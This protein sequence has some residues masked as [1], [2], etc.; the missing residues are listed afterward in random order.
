MNLDK[1]DKLQKLVQVR[2]TIQLAKVNEARRK[3]NQTREEI[4]FSYKKAEIIK[5]DGAGA[6]DSFLA[7]NDMKE[8]SYISRLTQLR[9]LKSKIDH[10]ITEIY[11]EI[12]RKKIAAIEI[13]KQIIV[14]QMEYEQARKRAE[15]IDTL[16]GIIKKEDHISR[17]NAQEADIIDSS[18][19]VNPDN[20][21]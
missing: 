9:S 3:L 11:N 18:I 4:T 15:K 20:R 17:E 5:R 1:F 2:E 6:V 21:I 10:E 7:G 8:G 13:E 14:L 16:H 19:R 12:E